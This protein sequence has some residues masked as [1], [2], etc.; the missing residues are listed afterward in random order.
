MARGKNKIVASY[1]GLLQA[2][3]KCI[4]P[5]YTYLNNAIVPK[6]RSSVI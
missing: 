2:P 5:L 6:N 3:P 1:H 4:G